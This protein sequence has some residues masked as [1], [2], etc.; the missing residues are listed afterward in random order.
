MRPCLRSLSYQPS[1]WKRKTLSPLEI[2]S[3]TLRN[4]TRLLTQTS[5][6]WRKHFDALRRKGSTPSTQRQCPEWSLGLR[7]YAL[8]VDWS[9][10]ALKNSTFTLTN[11]RLSSMCN[12]QRWFPTACSRWRR[13]EVLCLYRQLDEALVT[14]PHKWQ[15]IGFLHVWIQS[16]TIYVCTQRTIY[17]RQITLFLEG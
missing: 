6:P 7:Q 9:E 15:H 12:E 4:V 10:H 11:I 16:L 2:M 13:F 8:K 1:E 14:G 17:K 5:C 3:N